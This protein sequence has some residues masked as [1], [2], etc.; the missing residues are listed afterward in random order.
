MVVEA[1][2]GVFNTTLPKTISNINITISPFNV[3]PDATSKNAVL[4]LYKAG[5]VQSFAVLEGRRYMCNF[6]YPVA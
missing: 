1:G 4:T 6:S 2:T 5:V 3:A